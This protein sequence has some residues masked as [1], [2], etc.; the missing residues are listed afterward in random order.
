MDEAGTTGGGPFRRIAERLYAAP[1]LLL[2]V[3]PMMW[4]GNITLGRFVADHI[5]ALPLAQM[6]W[7]GAFLILLPFAWRHVA[8][9]LPAITRSLPILFV[10]A[11][12][13]ISAYNTLV[14][15]GLKDTTALSAALLQSFMPVMIAALA[16]VIYRERLTFFQGAGIAVSLVGVLLILS[17]GEP[18]TL[19]ALDFNRG[20]LWV[21]GAIFVY[22]LYTTVLKSRPRIHP[23]SLL[24]V[25]VAIGQA[26]LW[27][28]T[29]AALAA[30]SP[31]PLDL[32][33][34]ATGLYVTLFASL[35]AYFCFNRGVQLL[36][37]NRASPFFHLV[38]V[39]GSAFGIL[40]LGER[41]GWFH[42]AGWLTVLAGVAL[43]QRKPPPARG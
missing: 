16:L 39:F 4:G 12:T 10:L 3:P 41:L 18:S 28:F 24:L 25:L 8:R 20:D 14:Y 6:R 36:G 21:I 5:G 15:E 29:I 23:L 32:T 38:P 37:P 11:A 42:A 26:L 40:F 34:L 1:Y 33:T 43:A 2:V 17:R 35:L 19:L 9:D 13:G 30:G 31:F 27:P 22:A 7:T